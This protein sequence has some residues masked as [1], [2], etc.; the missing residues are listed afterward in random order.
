M[1]RTLCHLPT[2]DNELRFYLSNTWNFPKSEVAYG[3]LGVTYSMVGL[4]GASSDMWRISSSLNPEYDV[5]HYNLFSKMRSEAHMMMQNGDYENGLRTLSNSLPFIEK[6]LQCKVLHFPDQWKKECEELKSIVI[7]P[8]NYLAGEL[9]RLFNLRTT[10]QNELIN[11]KDDKRRNEILPS[12]QNNEMQIKNLQQSIQA[13]NIQIEMS[14][15]K[16]LLNKLTPI[17]S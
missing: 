13:R 12:I 2:Y 14:P 4:G 8:S 11:A 7:N 6:T 9:F 1:C 15:D 5:P 17:R 3:N 16:V 10:L